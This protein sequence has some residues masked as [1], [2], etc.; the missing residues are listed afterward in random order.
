MEGEELGFEFEMRWVKCSWMA[1]MG[2]GV[3]GK[4]GGDGIMVREQ[5]AKS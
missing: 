4:G 5:S 2:R 1:G 3:A